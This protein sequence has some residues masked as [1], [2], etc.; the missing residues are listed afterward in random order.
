[1]KRTCWFNV[2]AVVAFF[3]TTSRDAMTNPRTHCRFI[4]LSLHRTS[5]CSPILRTSAA[6]NAALPI[7]GPYLNGWLDIDARREERVRE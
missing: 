5:T 1:M 6:L 7:H 2:R 4:P 3:E